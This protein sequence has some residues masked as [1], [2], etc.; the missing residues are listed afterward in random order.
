ML[1]EAI[2]IKALMVSPTSP[3]PANMGSRIR[4]YHALKVLSSSCDVTFVALVE[5]ADRSEI[6]VARPFCSELHIV[7]KRLASRPFVAIRS[8]FSR[9]PYRV[10][11]F[12][13]KNLRNLLGQLLASDSY[14]IVW[15][16]FLNMFSHLPS[17]LPQRLLTVLDQHNADELM[18]VPYRRRGS[19]WNR[20]F[21][22][23]NIWKLRGFQRKVLKRVDVVLSVSGAEAEFMRERS[24]VSCDVWT[25]PNGVDVEFFQPGHEAKRPGHRIVFCGSMDVTMNADAALRFANGIFPLVRRRCP[26]AEF[27]VVGR[28]PGGAVKQLAERDGIVV[29]G[30]VED[31]RPYY[32][33]AR[34]L[35]A[36]FRYGAGTKLKIMEA[37]AMGVPVVSTDVGCHG[38]DVAHGRHLLI[39]NEDEGFARA[40]GELI[41]DDDLWQRLSLAGREL[42]L[43]DYSWENIMGSA[44]KGMEKLVQERR[45]K[46]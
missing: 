24:P 22:R 21:A 29:T 15:V 7:E 26:S 8:L 42:V 41:E 25:V 16:H 28:R 32:E 9:Y 10:V 37:M 34:V 38:I 35:V 13:N 1:R 27:W 23:Q 36:P 20:T 17:A 46:E 14:D 45:G 2:E 19:L 6:E 44:V 43:R 31:V 12:H 4:I 30:T 3:W 11:K 18:W 39:E 40:V 33:Q 5:E